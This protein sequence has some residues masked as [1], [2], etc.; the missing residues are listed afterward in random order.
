MNCNFLLLYRHRRTNKREDVVSN[1]F[2]LSLFTAETREHEVVT[3]VLRA[4]HKISCGRSHAAPIRT[5]YY[6]VEL[7]TTSVTGVN[8]VHIPV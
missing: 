6:S 7:A 4:V 2:G 1:S 5:P 3:V 8:Q